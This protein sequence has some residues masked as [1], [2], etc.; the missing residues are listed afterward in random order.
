MEFLPIILDSVMPLNESRPRNMHVTAEYF[1]DPETYFP[2]MLLHEILAI[3]IGFIT[4]VAT[5][6]IILAYLQN[7]CGMLKIVR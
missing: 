2:L 4:I 5:G 7:A 6:T 3:S 1:I